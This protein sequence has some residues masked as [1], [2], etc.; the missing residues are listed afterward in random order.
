MALV[1]RLVSS[2]VH[3]VNNALQ[4]IAGSVE[5]V[6]MAPA[7]SDMVAR[8]ITAIDTQTK[9]A[10]RL[11]QELSD[12]LRDARDGAERIDLK[13]AAQQVI[14]SRH[15]SLTKLHMTAAVEGDPVFL[16]ANPRH[17]QQMLLNLIVNAEESGASHV[18][19]RL[20]T[21]GDQG[22]VSVED[23][24]DVVRLKP[25][26]TGGAGSPPVS[27]SAV[28]AFEVSRSAA[29]S[30]ASGSSRTTNNLGIGLEV[31]SWLASQNGGSLIREP[32]AGLGSQALLRLPLS[33]G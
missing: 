26:T 18:T 23:N 12:F 17:L 20:G 1:A 19:V 24:A 4:V 29:S 7:A 32:L 15:Y 31:S 28:S 25:D 16:S 10:T 2:T 14:A 27:S 11:L 8:R 22:T 9:R 3:D 5:L 30:V 21:D 33:R 6:Q 13:A